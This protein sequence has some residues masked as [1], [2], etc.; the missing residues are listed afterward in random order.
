MAETSREVLQVE[1]AIFACPAEWESRLP[2]GIRR[3]TDAKELEK[4]RW[5]LLALTS[6]GCARLSNEKIRCQVLL[7]PGDCTTEQL[8]RVQAENVISYGLSP[9]DSLTLSSLAEPVLC[10]QRALPRPDG[11]V[12]EP[13]EL[14]LP[15]LPEPAVRLLPLLGV[16]L[17]HIPLTGEISLWYNYTKRRD[18]P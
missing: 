16:Q 4:R 18:F 7:V 11:G 13:Q 6:A 1:G 15:G 8:T 17:L 3:V 14:P 2:A 5:P 12:I 10:I 9:R